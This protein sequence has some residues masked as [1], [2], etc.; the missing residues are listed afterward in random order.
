MTGRSRSQAADEAITAAAVEELREHGY[1]GLTM[2]GVIERAGVSSAT[3]YRRFPTKQ[4]LVLATLQTV[5]ASPAGGDT[6][7]LE[8]DLEDL[9]KRVAKAIAGRDDLF[10]VL[11]VEVQFDD[12]LRAVSRAAFV[13]PRLRQVGELLDRAVARRELAERPPA[14][15]VL[16]LL[17]GPITH[18]AF[19][20]GEK[21]TPSFLRAVVRS[22]VGG[23]DRP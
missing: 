13:E 23:L 20:L 11:S 15:V 6:G 5:A 3:L 21:L 9:A 19:S 22:V 1:R 14:D 10:A 8:G 12:E 16:S 2:S 4:A 17:T 7:S 18:R